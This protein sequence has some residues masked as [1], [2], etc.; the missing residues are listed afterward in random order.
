MDLVAE[1]Y[2]KVHAPGH[3]R[4]RRKQGESI[5]SIPR[6]PGVSNRILGCKHIKDEGLAN[7]S[8]KEV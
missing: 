8:G 6:D 5:N 2:P 4:H 7:L 1:V 3:Q